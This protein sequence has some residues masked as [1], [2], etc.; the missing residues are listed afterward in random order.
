MICCWYHAVEGAE[1][2]QR[3]LDKNLQLNARVKEIAVPKKVLFQVN[4]D[5]LL[6]AQ[7]TTLCQSLGSA[8]HL[9]LRRM[10]RPILTQAELERINEVAPKILLLG[11]P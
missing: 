4:E 10:L 3:T 11:S 2:P 6:L 9:P 1:V 5:R 7:E 8:P